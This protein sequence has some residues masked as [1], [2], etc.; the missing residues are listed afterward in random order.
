[1]FSGHLRCARP[2]VGTAANES[3]VW[4]KV[5]TIVTIRDTMDARTLRRWANV[6]TSVASVT[7]YD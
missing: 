5:G 4:R 7:D 2:P 1:M 6:V 3:L